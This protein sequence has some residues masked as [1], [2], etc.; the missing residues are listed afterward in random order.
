MK[1]S[2]NLTLMLMIGIASLALFSG[3]VMGA[4]PATSTE[5]GKSD[6][7]S[8]LLELPYVDL[9]PVILDVTKDQDAG[10]ELFISNPIVNE[11][12]I[13]GDILFR[14]PPGMTI[15]SSMNCGG[16]SS[17]NIT[18][19]F[20]NDPLIPGGQKTISVWVRSQRIGTHEIKAKVTLW[21]EGK[22][23]ERYK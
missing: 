3:T 2:L 16:G 1:R 22:K 13:V 10:F 4:S 21:P 15:Y 17:G 8:S 23:K 20:V 18:C 19:P 14:V 9:R 12:N 5:S 7:D 6:E 11:I